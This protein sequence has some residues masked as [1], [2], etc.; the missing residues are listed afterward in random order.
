ME[1]SVEKYFRI[2]DGGYKK[3]GQAKKNISFSGP[4]ASVFGCWAFFFNQGDHT[5]SRKK[6]LSGN[7]NIV[8]LDA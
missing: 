1:I 7:H 4:P 5:P 3:L 2:V 6:K 8:E